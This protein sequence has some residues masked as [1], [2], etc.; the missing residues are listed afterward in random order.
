MAV[1][2]APP[3]QAQRLSCALIRP[4]SAQVIQAIETRP[5]IQLSAS[6]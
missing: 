5:V 1:A 4:A 3:T 2:S 6:Q